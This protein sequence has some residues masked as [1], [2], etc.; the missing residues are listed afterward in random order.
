MHSIL[1][2]LA[3]FPLRRT[4]DM[5][6][7]HLTVTSSPRRETVAACVLLLVQASL[8]CPR[9]QKGCDTCPLLRFLACPRKRKRHR[10]P[11][12]C[13]SAPA[14]GDRYFQELKNT[15]ASARPWP[16]RLSHAQLC[17]REKQKLSDPQRWIGSDR[18]SFFHEIEVEE[19]K[20]DGSSGGED[21]LFGRI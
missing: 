3:W 19:E 1:K 9:A 7:I 8:A 12:G 4:I 21:Q 17:F 2:K 13:S 20:E 10:G 11:V 15:E 16:P 14:G 18:P 6:Q 5:A